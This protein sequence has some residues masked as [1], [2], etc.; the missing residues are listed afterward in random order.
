MPA[1]IAAWL[2]MAASPRAGAQG[3][4]LS[5]TASA[6]SM[7]VS[8]SLTYT[9]N[10]TNLT[11]LLLT[12]AQVTNQLSAS[13]QLLSVGASQGSSTVN[14]S[15]VVFDLGEF[16]YPGSAQLTL[17][18]QPTAA[19]FITNT[20]TAS[21]VTVTNTASTNVVV[22]VTN[23]VA[24]LGVSL[25]GP[26][27]PVMANDWMTFV[28]TVTNAGPNAATGVILT[29][30]LPLGVGLKSVSPSSPAPGIAGS[31]LIFNLGTLA[32][33]AFTSFALNVQPTNAGTLLFSSFV[34]AAGV[35]DPNPTN[36]TAGTNI[37]VTGYLSSQLTTF[38]NSPQIYNMQNNLLEQFIT[39]TNAGTNAV[40]AVR[41]VVTGLTNR[42]FNAIGTN[43]GNPFVVF[44]AGLNTNQTVQLLL[45]YAANN[46]FPFTNSQL[47]AFAVDPPNWAAPPAASASTNINIFRIVKLSSGRML[48]WFPSITSRTYT[49]AYSDNLSSTNW[50]MAQPSVIA[51]AAFTEWIDYGPP[52]TV[53]APSVVGNRFYRVFLNP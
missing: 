17:T 1:L 24:D 12:D 13:V 2:M 27:Q 9:I 39:V 41:V 47:K 48:I 43:D 8:N 15:M 34:S 45:Q 10:L 5:V 30:T 44:G 53:S 16:T 3:F 33:G 49:V 28:V 21:S 14:G 6:V 11:G 46:Y 29:N 35:T 20:V 19:G 18:V 52:G 32:G 42:L 23:L 40:D 37:T 26:A 50:L 7:L 4:G 22:L 36:N 25:T 51:P 38:T 31:N